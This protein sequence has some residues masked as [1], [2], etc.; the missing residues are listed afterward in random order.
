MDNAS[1]YPISAAL[2]EA[3]QQFKTQLNEVQETDRAFGKKM[4]QWLDGELG[5]ETTIKDLKQ[6]ENIL[7]ERLDRSKLDLARAQAALTA[8]LQNA[9]LD[10]SATFTKT[11]G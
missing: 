7:F 3:L 5:E 6:K 8:T 1:Y 4:R 2:F 9:T 11:K 10:R